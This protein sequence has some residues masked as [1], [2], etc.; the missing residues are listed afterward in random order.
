MA[1]ELVIAVFTL[2]KSSHDIDADIAYQTTGTVA[3]HGI[4]VGTAPSRT[5]GLCFFE[6][7]PV[8]AGN[9]HTKPPGRVT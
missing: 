8:S 2:N 9:M 4:V 7:A 3:T 1:Q 6:V 5:P